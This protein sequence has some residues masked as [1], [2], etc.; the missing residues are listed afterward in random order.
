MRGLTRY[1]RD[2]CLSGRTAIVLPFTAATHLRPASVR[3]RPA[4][5]VASASCD[6][7]H[8]EPDG[9]GQPEP[10]GG[11]TPV[12][13]AGG[14]ASAPAPRTYHRVGGKLRARRTDG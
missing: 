7:V 8:Y 12:G 14:K 4:S 3:R 9:P 1:N 11:P 5:Q 13:Q 10:T 2:R 6:R